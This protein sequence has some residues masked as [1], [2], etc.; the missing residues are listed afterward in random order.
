MPRHSKA[1]RDICAPNSPLINIV[2]LLE[3]MH[4][5][6]LSE[7]SG[8]TGVSVSLAA[9]FFKGHVFHNNNPCHV[10]TS[11]AKRIAALLFPDTPNPQDKLARIVNGLEQCVV[12]KPANTP[13]STP[14]AANNKYARLNV[15]SGVTTGYQPEPGR[16]YLVRHADGKW[17][18]LIAPKNL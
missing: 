9:D 5:K 12:T 15:G 13:P 8:R 3:A 4:I 10:V 16:P 11:S 2:D 18:L 14:S 6:T 17:E 1:I 7:L